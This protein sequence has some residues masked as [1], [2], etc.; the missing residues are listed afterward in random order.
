MFSFFKKTGNL[1]PDLSFI[2]VDMHSHL[3]PALDDGLK[4][5]DEAIVLIDELHKL[6]YHKL[7]CT[8][9]IISDMYP[10]NPEVILSKFELVRSALKKSNID[11]TIEA[12]AEYMVD[13]EM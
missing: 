2:G 9:H 8:P 6:G 11:I 3:L 5:L 1:L 4:T 10:N 7:I 12:A 13:L